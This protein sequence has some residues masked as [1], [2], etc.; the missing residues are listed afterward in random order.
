[1]LGDVWEGLCSSLVFLF[2]LFSCGLVL[3]KTPGLLVICDSLMFN[4]RDMKE[5]NITYISGGYTGD[6]GQYYS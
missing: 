2:P 6:Y 3:G 1:M 4:I 5:Y